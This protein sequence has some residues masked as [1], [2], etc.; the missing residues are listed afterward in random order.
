[1]QTGYLRG[2]IRAG[3]RMPLK[4]CPFCN[5]SDLI[6]RDLDGAYYI[7]C[8]DCEA[9]GPDAKMTEDAEWKWNQREG[10]K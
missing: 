7:T 9:R 10:A 8:L 6:K 4:P 1:M 2:D 3:E 5:G